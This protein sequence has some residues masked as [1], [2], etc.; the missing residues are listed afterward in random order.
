MGLLGPLVCCLWSLGG[1]PIV[2]LGWVPLV[3]GTWLHGP[4]GSCGVH[5]K[6]AVRRVHQIEDLKSNLRDL[7][8]VTWQIES[9]TEQKNL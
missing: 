4:F 2:H 7:L 3:E 8:E 9:Q 6:L 1:L 5:L